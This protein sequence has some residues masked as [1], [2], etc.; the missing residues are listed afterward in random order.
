MDPF[1]TGVT[2]TQSASNDAACPVTVLRHLYELCPSWTPLAPVFTHPTEDRP[3]GKA[4]TWEY[5][6][7]H[8]RELLGLLGVRGSYSGHS[9]RW[10]SASSA[11]VAILPEYKIQLLGRL[12][13]NAYQDYIDF[14]PTQVF[15]IAHS[16]Q[17]SLEH[18]P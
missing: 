6:A 5:L 3:G 1:H 2:I 15:Q 10:R 13:A 7:Q 11:K 16:F 12:L 8:L 17:N 4:F 14:H 9:F 18:Y